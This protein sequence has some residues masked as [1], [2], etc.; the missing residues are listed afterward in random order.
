MDPANYSAD[1]Y[2]YGGWETVPAIFLKQAT[3]NTYW[4]DLI[5]GHII[6]WEFNHHKYVDHTWSGVAG[7]ISSFL[8]TSSRVETPDSWFSG[9]VGEDDHISLTGI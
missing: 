2:V 7:F 5:K 1:D 3:I 4:G 8:A 6:Q 9:Y